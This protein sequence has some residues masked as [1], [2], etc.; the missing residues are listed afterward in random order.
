MDLIKKAAALRLSKTVVP[1]PFVEQ[2]R[3]IFA[4]VPVVPGVL[5]PI[6][7]GGLVVSVRATAVLGYGDT[8]EPEDSFELGTGAVKVDFAPVTEAAVQAPQG[9]GLVQVQLE[10][11][12]EINSQ[13]FVED[14]WEDEVGEYH[15]WS[16]HPQFEALPKNADDY[17]HLCYQSKI[18][19]FPVLNAFDHI[20]GLIVFNARLRKGLPPDRVP[21]ACS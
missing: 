6:D 10:P 3:V 13:Y 14:G 4:T 2:D 20:F 21:Q 9:R 5:E 15:E 19:G 17:E 1:A 7:R 16:D 12:D 8:F 18:G 11:F